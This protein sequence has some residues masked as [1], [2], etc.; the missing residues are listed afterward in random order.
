VGSKVKL[1]FALLALAVG[2]ACTTDAPPDGGAQESD[3]AVPPP[4]LDLEAVGRLLLERM[5]VQPGERVLLVGAPGR[6]DPLVTALRSGVQGADGEDLGAWAVEGPAPDSWTTD[7]TEAL[8]GLEG[9]ALVAA[10]SGVDLGVML[11]GASPSHPVYAALQEVLRRG[12]GRT[13]HFHWSGAYGLDGVMLPVDA[14]VDAFYERVLLETDYAALARA[15]AAFEEAMR[16]ATVRVTTPA[17]TDVRFQIGARPVTRQDGDASA[18][19]SAEARNLIDREVELPA[20]A[21][22]VA[23]NE[24]SVQGTIAFPPST[25]SGEPVDGL[26][27]TFEE[28]RVVDAVADRGLGAAVAEMDGAGPAGRAFREF[29]LGFN[30]LMAV[31]R[32]GTPWIPYYGY[33]AGV[34]RLSLG[35]NSELGG[36]VEGGYVRWNFFTDATVTVDGETWVE[37]GRLIRP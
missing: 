11:P 7:F 22:R 2:S 20:G 19:R 36:A 9:D 37:S 27:V 3:A 30:P 25:W 35:D 4:A 13:V 33:G 17:G 12:Q 28:G 15:E 10:L 23:P 24:A 18:A 31:Q 34:V 14:E 16:G 5:D 6:F 21:I 26:I 8:R 29:A 32:E 1:T